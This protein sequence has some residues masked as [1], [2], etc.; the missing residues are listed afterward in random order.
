[1]VLDELTVPIVQAPMAGGPST[2]EL[3]AAVCEAGGLGF[4]AAG[5]KT[6]DAMWADVSAVR[7]LTGRQFGVNVFSPG[8]GP[9]EPAVVDAYATRL[10]GEAERAGAEL[11]A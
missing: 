7:E 5:Y 3:A 6:A 11:G 4:V 2:P 8:A 1:M 9:A 10:R